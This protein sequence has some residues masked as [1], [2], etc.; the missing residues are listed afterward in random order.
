MICHSLALHMLLVF[1]VREHLAWNLRLTTEGPRASI[2]IARVLA[3][4]DVQVVIAEAEADRAL[5]SD[6]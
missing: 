3:S 4:I 6:R 1:C 2:Y 5:T